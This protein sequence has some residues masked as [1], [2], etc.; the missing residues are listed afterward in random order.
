[1]NV[2]RI[3]SS[4]TFCPAD[5]EPTGAGVEVGAASSLIVTA[6]SFAHFLQTA[7]CRRRERTDLL[8]PRRAAASGRGSAGN[9]AGQGSKSRDA[10]RASLSP[11]DPGLAKTPLAETLS[12]DGSISM[13]EK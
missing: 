3:P 7:E 2:L 12:I 9:G 4:K 5:G 11:E 1:M 10:R 8:F 13:T 6:A